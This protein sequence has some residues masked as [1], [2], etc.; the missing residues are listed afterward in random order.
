MLIFGIRK[1]LLDV[2]LVIRLTGTNEEEAR[3]LLTEKGYKVGSSMQD[4][5]KEIIALTQDK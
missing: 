1:E 3:Q 2:P 5:V 4:A